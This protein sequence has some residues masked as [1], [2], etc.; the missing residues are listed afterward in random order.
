MLT[1]GTHTFPRQSAGVS[2]Q[3]FTH[4]GHTVD[5]YYVIRNGFNAANQSAM[6]M[7]QNPKNNFES[8]YS[9]I[10]EIIKAESAEQAVAECSAT[11]YN[12]Q[13]LW[14]TRTPKKHK[15]LTAA[16]RAYER[17]VY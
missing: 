12:G 6:W 4:R 8:G 2:F 16:I 1:T 13:K 9:E 17:R 3:S 10:V 5:T 7:E 11:C 14:A 15:G